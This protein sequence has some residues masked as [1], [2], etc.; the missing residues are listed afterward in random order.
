MNGSCDIC[1]YDRKRAELTG[2][3][4]VVEFSEDLLILSCADGN[5]SIEGSSM[6]IERFDCDSGKL[7]VTGTIDGFQFYND[8][9]SGKKSKRLF[10]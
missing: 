4:D 2:I 6:K 1:I 3:C 9:P 7:S 10:K 8:A 5:I